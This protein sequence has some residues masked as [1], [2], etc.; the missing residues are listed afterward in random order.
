MNARC[1]VIR[2]CIESF[3]AQQIYEVVVSKQLAQCLRHKDE[4]TSR[5]F[6]LSDQDAFPIHIL[7]VRAY[8]RGRR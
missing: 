8:Q 1:Q 4:A 6:A 7:L 3:C 2:K 5:R